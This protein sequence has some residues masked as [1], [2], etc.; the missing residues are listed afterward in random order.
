MQTGGPDGDLGSNEILLSNDKTVAIIDGSGVLY[1]PQ[2]LNRPE[3]IRL[4]K[5]R[6]MI[7]DFD[8]A[9]L[10]PEGYKVL[11]SDQDYKLPTGEIVP[12]GTEFRNSFH[13][14]VKCDL[15][16]P[17]GG[18]PESVNI[19][20]VSQLVDSEGKPNFKYV[21]EGANL[22]VS[23]QARFWL[24]KKGVVL[25]KDS[26]TNKGG[27]TSSSFEVLAG[28]AQNDEEFINNMIFKDGKKSAFYESYVKDIQ[29]KI[30]EN[31]AA[32]FNCI[33]KEW[34]ARKGLSTRTAISDELSVTLNKLQDELERS[35]LY[36]NEVSR[37]NVLAQHFPQTLLDKVGLDLLLQ[38]LDPQYLR[39][40]W[41]AKLSAS[42]IYEKGVQASMVDFYHA[43]K[44]YE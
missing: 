26:S 22:F 9:K 6:K 12:D 8:S 23:Q 41:S 25:Y 17:C 44:Q 4:A 39:A 40:A 37:R 28:L 14:R 5:G 2:G 27:V 35:D 13:L 16:V 18:R 1:D 10:G 33:N 29:K 19:S 32:E 38:R 15:F 24:E 7:G 11:V 21:V 3:L 34:H 42:F 20:N 31:A 30:C 36:D 43:I